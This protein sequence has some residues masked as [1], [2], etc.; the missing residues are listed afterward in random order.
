MLDKYAELIK[1]L[2]EEHKESS[3]LNINSRVLII[4]STNSFIRCFS[5]IPA[6]NDNGEHIGGSL[7]FLRS[8]GAAIRQFKPTRVIAVFDG[9]GGSSAR[10]KVYDGYKANRLNPKSFNRPE[11]FDSIEHEQ[12]SM[13]NQFTRLV[14]Y[15]RCLP[16][17]TIV[18]DH[19]EADDVIAYACTSYFQDKSDQIIIMS[20]D[21]DYLQLANDKVSIYRPV[22][23]KLYSQNEVEARFKVSAQNYL[24]YKVFI[25]DTSD[26]VP[27]VNGIGEKTILNKIPILT[28]RRHITKEELFDYCEKHK[29]YEKKLKLILEQRDIVERNYA[30]MQLHD[31]NIAANT[32][33][34]IIDRL[35]EEVTSTNKSQFKQLLLLDSGTGYIKDVDYWL[36]TFNNLSAY[37]FQSKDL[38]K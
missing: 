10:K 6:L 29:K 20:D 16:I 28:E 30:L 19:V 7:G 4:D 21:K 27:G 36:T 25:G 15:L 31:V 1:Q 33:L 34:L 23:K 11:L 9:K 37:S 18:L 17:T 32:K 2:R 24:M 35:N 5:A 26:N 3:Q 14:Q 22:E 38:K 12:E 8:I 13:V